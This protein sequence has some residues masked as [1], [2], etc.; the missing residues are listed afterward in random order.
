MSDITRQDLEKQALHA[1]CTC[2]YYDLADSIGEIDDEHLHKIIDIPF[3]SHIQDWLYN[4]ENSSVDEFIE[5]M[6]DCYKLNH[7]GA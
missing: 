4:S 5:Q 1:E 3:Y 6:N 7:K 2:W